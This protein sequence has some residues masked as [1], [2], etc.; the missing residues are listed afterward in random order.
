MKFESLI[1]PER[2]ISPLVP[3]SIGILIDIIDIITPT[4]A[5]LSIFFA[6][7]V[8]IAG[9]YNGLLWSII[10]AFSLPF[11]RFFIATEIEHLWSPFYN[12]LNAIDRFV[13]LSIVS[14][15]SAK[16]SSSVNYLRHKV[17]VLEGLVPVC[18]NCKKI[19]NQNQE[20][21]PMEQYIS[22]HSEAKFTHGICPDC[23][24]LLYRDNIKKS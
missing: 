4:E 6:I 1:D 24:I 11:S 12:I 17:K 16:L 20:W 19:R 7:P 14:L 18:A 22:E 2:K 21:Q 9:W 15:L 13:V 10:I 5:Q 8:I 3:I 23:M